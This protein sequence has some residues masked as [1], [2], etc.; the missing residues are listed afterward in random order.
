MSG[1]GEFDRRVTLQRRGADANGDR[2]GAWGAVATRDARIVYLKGGEAVQGQRLEGEQPAVIY[3]RKDADTVL[4]DNAW[5]AFDA[6]AAAPP[7]DDA[8][9]FGVTSAIWN[10]QTDEIEIL[11]VVRKN[12]SDA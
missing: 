5:R 7:A 6:R 1:A 10:R 12:G 2:T 9:V 11:A 4:V 3:V 8:E